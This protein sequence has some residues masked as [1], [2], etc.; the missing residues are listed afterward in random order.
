MAEETIGTTTP[1]AVLNPIP[2]SSRHAMTPEAASSPKALPPLSTT[3]K[4]RSTRRA[5]SRRLV[6]LVPGEPPRTSTPP[7]AP[8]R[9]STT[10]QP[11]PLT[12]SV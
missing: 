5:G 8:S 4:T 11:V 7:A 12:K 9:H 10:V 3:A 6:S 2:C 1:P